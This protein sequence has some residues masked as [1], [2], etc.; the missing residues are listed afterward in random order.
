MKIN[1]HHGLNS[2]VVS[3]VPHPTMQRFSWIFS[4]ISVYVKENPFLDSI[5]LSSNSTSQNLVFFYFSKIYFLALFSEVL[6]YF[7][8]DKL[9]QI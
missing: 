6:I 9:D 4:A 8:L 3:M 7:F 5:K 2:K 1:K